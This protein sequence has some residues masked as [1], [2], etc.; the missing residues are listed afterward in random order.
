ML[1]RVPVGNGVVL[2]NACPGTGDRYPPAVSSTTR[3]TTIVKYD[4]WRLLE[5]ELRIL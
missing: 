5:A 1:D 4:F 2:N 3:A